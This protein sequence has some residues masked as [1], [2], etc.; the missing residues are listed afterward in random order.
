MLLRSWSDLPL[1][2]PLRYAGGAPG[3]GFIGR[4][5]RL[6][7]CAHICTSVPPASSVGRGDPWP[8]PKEFPYPDTAPN[9]F[10]CYNNETYAQRREGPCGSWCVDCKGFGHG[11]GTE[12]ICSTGP[13][14]TGCPPPPA[15]PV[16]FPLVKL[17]EYVESHGARCLDGSPASFYVQGAEQ[18]MSSTDFIVDF[19]G[20]GW[21]CELSLSLSR[22]RSLSLSRARAASSSLPLPLP[23]PLPLLLTLALALALALALDV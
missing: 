23:L 20:G 11:C 14:F 9:T 13:G 16:P 2:A 3:P 4:L 10:A 19:E 22:G 7:F 15:P 1:G 6:L 8:C 12:P 5:M 21:W 17:P 18:N